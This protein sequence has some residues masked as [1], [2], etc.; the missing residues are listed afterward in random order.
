LAQSLQ[1]YGLAKYGEYQKLVE[2][3]KLG[4]RIS[5]TNSL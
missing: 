3:E 2:K 5:E 1:D 4:V